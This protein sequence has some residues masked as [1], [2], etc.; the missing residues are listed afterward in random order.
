[1]E[2]LTSVWNAS[3]LG[4]CLGALCAWFSA[5]WRGSR[6]IRAFV[7]PLAGPREGSVFARLWVW[8]RGKAHRLYLFLRLDRLLDG[9]VFLR[10]CIW[11]GLTVVLAPVLPT[12]AVLAL[13]L[14]GSASVLLIAA[15]DDAPAPGR[16]P[17]DRYILLYAFIYLAATLLSV[18]PASSLNSGLLTAAFVLFPLALSRAVQDRAQLD[19]LVSAMVLAGAAVSLYG[20][21]QYLF[22][23]GY[24]SAAWVDGDMFSS[25]SFRVA[26]TMQNPNMLGQYLILA[27]PLGGAKLLSARGW[28]ARVWYF[29]CCAAMCLCMILTFSRG[30]WLGLLLAGAVFLA[31]V[32]PRLLI[33]IPA[34]LA[35]MYFLLPETVV[36]R[37]TSI[38]DLAD[39][40]TNY[41]VYIW[42]GVLDMLKDYWLCGIGPGDV[43]FNRVYPAYSYNS[44]SAP[45]AHSLFLQIVC[46][47]GA[48]A[49]IVFV[50][51]IFVYL[52]M[53]CGA[54]SREKD[55]DSRLLQTALTAGVLG[56]LLQAMT[57]YSFYNYRVMLLFWSYL[58]L[59]GLAARRGELNGGRLR[60]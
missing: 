52:R 13:A 24:Q 1:M 34:A 31:F 40:S 57:D 4:R 25:I 23:W 16:T 3:L 11:C 18:D 35:V 30:A 60:A 51:L 59:G 45:H 36:S 21:C 50:V 54:V 38:G 14:V 53:M 58:A 29:C 7:S 26:S 6:T 9:S 5:Q 2:R 49:L 22:G 37:F 28:G 48:C 44:I 41:R 47:A 8:L 10:P 33:L 27:I 17:I 55:R 56:F 15:R 46:D 43:A 42:L 39:A 12:M 32:N 20:V 19:V